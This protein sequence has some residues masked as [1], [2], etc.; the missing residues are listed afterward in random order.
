MSFGTDSEI[1][2]RSLRP[3]ERFFEAMRIFSMPPVVL[4]EGQTSASLNAAFLGPS[5]PSESKDI[6]LHHDE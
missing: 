5:G 1:S 2:N 6:A 4:E 3:A